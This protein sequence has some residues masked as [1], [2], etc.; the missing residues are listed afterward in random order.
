MG[1][2]GARAH[3]SPRRPLKW[4]APSRPPAWS[5]YL[6]AR[7]RA[8]RVIAAS[9]WPAPPPPARRQ[10]PARTLCAHRGSITIIDRAQAELDSFWRPAALHPARGP[11]GRIQLDATGAGKRERG[12]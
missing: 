6:M 11:S 8:R 7:A 2:G 1:P 10:L 9:D 12:I 4:R 3:L 5:I